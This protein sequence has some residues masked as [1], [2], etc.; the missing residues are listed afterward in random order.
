MAGFY[1]MA[2]GEPYSPTRQ[3]WPQVVEYNFR[4][5]GHELRAFLPSPSAEEIAGFKNGRIEFAVTQ[6]EGVIFF[7]YQIG[8]GQTPPIS[9]QRESKPRPVIPWSDAPFSWWLVDEE[10][11][12]LPNPEPTPLERGLIM[13]PL[14]DANTGIV[15]VIRAVSL[16][17][18]VSQE[19]D[20]LIREEAAQPFMGRAAHDAAIERV[21]AKYKDGLS[22][23]KTAKARG[24]AGQSEGAE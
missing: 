5:G 3:K 10:N 24:V 22:M 18:N 23:V 13:V 8:S 2:V 16:P 14:V 19:V 20:R 11:R 7:L 4:G 1:K 12:T 15:K 17:P 9:R 6:L 21:Y